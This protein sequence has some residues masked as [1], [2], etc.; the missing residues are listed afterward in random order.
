MLFP[1]EIDVPAGLNPEIDALAERGSVFLPEQFRLTMTCGILELLAHDEKPGTG[2]RVDFVSGKA[3]WRREHGGGKGQAVARACF[4]KGLAE[5]EIFDAT[6]GLARDAFVLAG[7]GARVTMFERNPAV[8]AL[9]WDGLRRGS[10][11]P[12]IGSLI[13]ERLVLSSHA[14]ILE[15]GESGV[16]DS[17]YLDPMFPPKKGSALVKKDM[18]AFHALVGADE[19]SGELLEAAL[20][21]ARKRV[22][23][24]RPSG[25]PYLGDCMTANSIDTK[26]L[27]FDLY[28]PG[29]SLMPSAKK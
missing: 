2:V 9:L 20:R 7:L 3:A 19:D 26:G 14:S 5:P 17:V 21:L 11:D 12:E 16:C 1:L 24:K 23:V 27:R 22:A 28:L 6:A 13:R 29:Q 18:R 8:R 25:A 10:E 15:I 4:P